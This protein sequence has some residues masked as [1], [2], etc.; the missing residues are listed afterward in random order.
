MQHE[1]LQAAVGQLR[2]LLGG[3]ELG[4][5][6][7]GKG[8]L[9]GA[10]GRRRLDVD[11]LAGDVAVLGRDDLAR[12]QDQGA[13]GTAERLLGVDA[14]GAAGEHLQAQRLAVDVAAQGAGQLGEAEVGQLLR[15]RQRLQRRLGPGRGH[16]GRQARRPRQVVAVV[17]Q[18]DDPARAAPLLGQLLDQPL[19]VREQTRVDDVLVQALVGEALADAHRGDRLT[20][21][22]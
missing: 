12:A 22:A 18:V 3:V 6:P 17:P 21:L 11:V 20:L 10:L 7:L 9:I 5:Q 13:L 15:R 8:V 2:L 19:V 14:H 1:A 4:D 16:A